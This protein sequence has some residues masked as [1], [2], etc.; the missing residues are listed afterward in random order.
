MLVLAM[1]FSRIA[2][3]W[4]PLEEGDAPSPRRQVGGGAGAA[5]LHNGRQNGYR[6]VSWDCHGA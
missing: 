3:G 4:G 2:G 1:K 6:R 5:H